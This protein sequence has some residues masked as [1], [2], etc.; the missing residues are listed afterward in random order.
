MNTKFKYPW[1]YYRVF[2]DFLKTSLTWSVFELETCFFFFKL[3][4]S[5][6]IAVF[7]TK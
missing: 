3:I 7:P 6:I 5:I 2:M 1:I 4:G